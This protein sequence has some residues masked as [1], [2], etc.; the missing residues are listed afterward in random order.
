MRSPVPLTFE[1]SA[2]A[3]RVKGADASLSDRASSTL[4]PPNTDQVRQL[5]GGRGTS[6]RLPKPVPFR[7]QLA[8]PFAN[9]ASLPAR[10]PKKLHVHDGSCS[11]LVNAKQPLQLDDGFIGLLTRGNQLEHSEARS[12]PMRMA[13]VGSLCS[14][15]ARSISSGASRQSS[16][17]SFQNPVIAPSQ[18]GV[19]ARRLTANV[20]ATGADRQRPDCTDQPDSALSKGQRRAPKDPA[21][22]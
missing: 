4:D 10:Y 1:G 11:D 3:R 12:T 6:G 13:R 16:S 5:S 18:A 20:T 15:T 22:A 2:S 21:S 9:V 19:L 17:L 8:D 7:F 14:S